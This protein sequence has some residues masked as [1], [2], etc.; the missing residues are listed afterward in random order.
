MISF[1]LPWLAM[2]M[3]NG[4]MTNSVTMHEIFLCFRL[5]SSFSDR[6]TKLMMMM[7]TT[8]LMTMKVIVYSP[9]QFSSPSLDFVA[10][11]VLVNDVDLLLMLLICHNAVS[12]LHSHCYYLTDL[13]TFSLCSTQEQVTV[14]GR[15][16]AISIQVFEN[17]GHDVILEEVVMVIDEISMKVGVTDVISTAVK[18]IAVI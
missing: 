14:Y 7:T 10:V 5:V 4:M 16:V 15:I 9:V 3:V 12:H 17:V 13:E 6:P 2:V 8:M 11:Q 18:V 1:V